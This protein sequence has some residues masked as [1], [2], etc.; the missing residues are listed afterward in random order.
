MIT[1]ALQLNHK[2]EKRKEKKTLLLTSG[3]FF[4]RIFATWRQNKS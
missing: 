4:G 1:T 2:F 3:L